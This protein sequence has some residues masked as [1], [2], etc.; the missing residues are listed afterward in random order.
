MFESLLEKLLQ[1]HLKDYIIGLDSTKLKLGVWNGNILI[2]NVSIN[3]KLIELFELPFQLIFSNIG[4]MNIAIP[5]N[6][7]SSK[8]VE[9]I[10]HDFLL[11]LS[12]EKTHSFENDSKP[13]FLQEK[14]DFL[15]KIKEEFLKK[16][17]QKKTEKKP[18]STS[19]IQKLSKLVFDNMQITIN[20]ALGFSPLIRNGKRIF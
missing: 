16:I 9:I 11:I 14:L 8:P 10:L 2:E 3:S 19:Y 7:L 17:S 13:R 6:K 15:T 1:K 12:I 5:W 18:V 20:K 4:R